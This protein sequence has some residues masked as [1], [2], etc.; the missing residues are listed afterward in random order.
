[1]RACI[2]LHFGTFMLRIFTRRTRSYAH[3]HTHAHALTRARA[4]TGKKAL[5]EGILTA[6]LGFGKIAKQNG[7]RV[8]GQMMAGNMKHAVK[9]LKLREN[10]FT[11]ISKRAFMPVL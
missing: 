8:L 2:G 9:V 5:S 1:M 4:L 10:R 3:N 7:D 11:Q 6:C